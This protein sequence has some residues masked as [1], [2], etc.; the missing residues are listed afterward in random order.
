ML[1]KDGQK[2]R[3]LGIAGK[4]GQVEVGTLALV[5][6]SVREKIADPKLEF[7]ESAKVIAGAL[8][9]FAKADVTVRALLYQGTP[10]EATA[11][12]KKHPEFHLIICKSPQEEPPPIEMINNT[13]LAMVGQKGRHLGIAGIFRDANNPKKFELHWEKMAL[14][15][16]YETPEAKVADHAVISLMQEYAQQV[17]DQNLL[18]LYPKS[19][20]PLKVKF[21][22]EKVEFVGSQKCQRCHEA[23][24]AI[25]QNSRHSH[26]Y[27]SLVNHAK[28]PT[29]RQFDGECVICH[30]IGFAYAS[31]YK[32]AELTPNLKDVGCENCHGPGSL[33]VA[34]PNNP[35]FY[36]DQSPWKSK[37]TDRV[38]LADGK[39]DSTVLL[40][41][42]GVCQKCHDTDNDP[43][44]KF[45]EY[46]PKITHG[47]KAAPPAV[48]NG[49]AAPKK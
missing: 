31:G 7:E 35:A 47:K 26:A 30:T 32:N 6:P 5:A 13:M 4:P 9:S 19:P 44:F 10:D 16:A 20:H 34:Q 39:Y 37:P 17:R 1:A 38:M 27:D 11:L 12:A 49:A 15:D 42:D 36:G 21:P 28:K 41:I 46:W 48:I 2:C 14:T 40:K 45:E 33:H 29:L 8:G 43:K 22:G 23:D 3:H 25:W 24:Y 18:A